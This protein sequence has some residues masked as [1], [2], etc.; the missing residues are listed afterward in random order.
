MQPT[1]DVL[2]VSLGTARAVMGVLNPD[3]DAA[4]P[5]YARL[6]E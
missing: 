5:R 3:H 6:M 4:T 1:R 2:V